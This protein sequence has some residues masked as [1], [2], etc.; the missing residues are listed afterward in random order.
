MFDSS[1]AFVGVL[2]LL[3]CRAVVSWRLRNGRSGVLTHPQTRAHHICGFGELRVIV[4]IA[5]R[6]RGSNP[7]AAAPYV[8][9]VQ[10]SVDSVGTHVYHGG[11]CSHVKAAIAYYCRGLDAV[12][13]VSA[14]GSMYRGS[15]SPVIALIACRC[16]MLSPVVPLRYRMSPPSLH[17]GF[18]RRDAQVPGLCVHRVA[19]AITVS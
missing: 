19:T 6:C 14:A 8:V 13:I 11:S 9:V 10:S 12:A 1:R 16:R 7:V 5:W 15:C 2:T 4:V 18:I 17:T 3:S